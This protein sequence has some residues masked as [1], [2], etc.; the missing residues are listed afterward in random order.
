MIGRVDIEAAYERIT[1][2]IR[3]TP[4]MHMDADA[5]GLGY[6]VMLKMPDSAF[7]TKPEDQIPPGIGA[8]KS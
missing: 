6:P 1:P 4:I 7:N 5:F 8:Q 3:R 2:Y